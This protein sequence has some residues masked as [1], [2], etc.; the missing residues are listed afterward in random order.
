ME[1]ADMS[2]RELLAAGAASALAPMFPT[3]HAEHDLVIL[4]GRVMDPETKLDAVR[5][6]GVQG[7][8][9]VAVST[10]ELKG[11]RTIDARG[12]VVAPGFIDPISHGQ[13]LENDRLQAL[14]GVTT[15]LQMEAGVSSV[16]AW[17]KDQEGKRI[18]N[19]GAGTG[20]TQARQMVLG[21]WAAAET[22]VANETQVAAMAAI[23]DRNLK[24]GGLGVGFGLEYQP[25]STRWEV[26][27]MFRVAGQYGAS[28]HVHTRY[29]TLL[30]EQ[31]NL[32]AV[33]EVIANS[34]ATG[35]PVH[36]VHVPSMALANTPRA[37]AMIESA[38]RRG[39]DVTCDFYPYTAFGTGIETEVFA[40]GWQTK[41]GISYSDLEWAK[42]HERMT[43][44]TFAK[45]R[46]EGGSVIAHAIPEAAVRAAAASPATMVG[47]DG[48]LENGVGHP[49]SSGT[50]A[51]VL[52]KYVREE[53]LLTLMQ[54]L[55]KMSLRQARRFERRCPDFRR[56]GRIRVGADADLA[57][58]D[59]AT[60][61]D[62]ATFDHPAQ[63]STGFRH[64]LV[65]GI[66]VVADGRLVEDAL[67]G[68]GLRAR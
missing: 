7:G 52:G 24:A 30:E 20:H 5:H 18:L 19:Y 63:T 31:S 48:S 46:K 2:R 58:F 51:R 29:G 59:P 34:V 1:G 40:E 3:G 8:R 38:Q 12:L 23:V 11:R 61:I 13:D 44:E 60:V 68:R 49:R 39:I 15:K 6:L 35:A 27:E 43:A 42:T 14:D 62:R 47:S 17:Y 65:G 36:I 26:F 21:G 66:A 9:I 53:K 32:T 56:K 37:L 67:P 33:Q 41:F 45:Y 50:F 4:N 64:V 16:A 55:E 25:A 22:K 57:I 54:A 28:C 10:K